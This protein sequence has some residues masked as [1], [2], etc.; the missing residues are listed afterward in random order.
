MGAVVLYYNNL[1]YSSATDEHL[2]IYFKIKTIILLE[3]DEN[4]E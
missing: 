1:L 2:R 3:R 4:N